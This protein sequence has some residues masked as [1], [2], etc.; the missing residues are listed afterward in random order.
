MKVLKVL[1]VLAVLAVLQY[2]KYMT[3]LEFDHQLTHNVKARD[4][5]GSKKDLLRLSK[6]Q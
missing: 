6:D 2:Y 3:V 4:P 1:V 5:V